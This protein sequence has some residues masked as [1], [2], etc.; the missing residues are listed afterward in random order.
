ML[1]GGNGIPGPKGDPVRVKMN[2]ISTVYDHS[3][4]LYTD[5]GC[6]F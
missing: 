4:D 6:C 3:T 2:Q 5:A 1:Q